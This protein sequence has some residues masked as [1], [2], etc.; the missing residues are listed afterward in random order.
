M[1]K[2]FIR[3]ISMLLALLI[4][5][6]TL[7][8]QTMA[9]AMD[10][11]PE[12]INSNFYL[13]KDYAWSLKFIANQTTTAMFNESSSDGWNHQEDFY[14]IRDG[15]VSTLNNNQ[16]DIFRITSNNQKNKF[17]Y[18]YKNVG[19][20]N[21]CTVDLKITVKDWSKL[22]KAVTVTEGNAKGRNNYPFIAFRKDK[23]DV[24]VSTV[25]KVYA[26][27]FTYQFYNHDTG[28]LLDVKG[29]TTL[30]DIDG[31]S[32]TSNYPYGEIVSFSSGLASS[33][34]TYWTEDTKLYY[35]S[36]TKS[37]YCGASGTCSDNDKSNWLEVFFDG[38]CFEFS[39]DS[40]N[41]TCKDDYVP[42]TAPAKSRTYYHFLMTSDTLAK[43][44]TPNITKEVDKAS[45]NGETDTLLYSMSFYLPAIEADSRYSS[46][47]IEDDIPEA[48]DI[49]NYNIVDDSGANRNNH[50]NFIFENSKIMVSA[51]DAASN[52]LYGTDGTT[53]QLNLECKVSNADKL[54]NYIN[55]NICTISN[56][57]SLTTE[58]GTSTSNVV[59]TDVFYTLTTNI[60]NGTISN[61]NS[62]ICPLSNETITF[63][64]DTDYYV[65]SVTVDGIEIDAAPYKNGGS[66]SFSNIKANH[67]ISVI[68]SPYEYFNINIKYLDE[69]NTPLS[70]EYNQSLRSEKS[71]NVNDIVNKDIQYYTLSSIEGVTEGTINDDVNIIVR[72]KRNKN[73]I[74]INYIEKETNSKL[75][76]SFEKTYAQGTDYNLTSEAEQQIQ[77][78]TI[79][80]IEGS[81]SGTITD[82]IVIN[83]YY[84]RNQN[85]IT[86]NYLE[87][88]TNEKL[89][90]T[91]TLTYPQGSEYDV[92]SQTN[93]N[94][95]YYTVN[96]IQGDKVNGSMDCDKVINV[97]YSR[98]QN[99]I[100]INFI[101]WITK[102]AISPFIDK[103]QEQG[104]DYN[105]IADAT[106]DIPYY[107]YYDS[108]GNLYGVLIA[109]ETINSYYIRNE[110]TITIKYVE[111]G[112]E[113]LLAD[114]V[115]Y[116]EFQGT[117]YDVTD[118]ANK[119]IACYN[120][121][122]VE[123]ASK[124]FITDDVEIIVYYTA[125]DTS[126]IV[127]YIDS[128]GKTLANSETI[129]GKV[130]DNYTT[131]KKNI[132]GYVLTETP[133]NAKGIMTEDIIVVDYIYSLKPADVIANYKTEA[134]EQLAESIQIDGKVFD[135][136]NT[137]QM[138]FYGYELIEVPEN[139]AGKMSEETIIVDY[140]YKLKD[141]SVTVNYIDTENNKLAD[142][143]VI[144]GKVFSEYETAPKNIQYYSLLV[145][146]ENSTGKMSEE[147]IV[148]NYVYSRNNNTVTINYLDKDS[149]EKLADS[150]NQVI[151]QG[152]EYDVT[153]NVQKEIEHYSL[154]S[155]IGEA[156]GF[157]TDDINIDVYYNRNVGTIV[158]NYL[159]EYENSISDSETYSG[160][161]LDEYI[162]EAKDIY[163]YELTGTPDNA[164]GTYT[165]NPITINY[166]YALKDAMVVIEHLDTD[167]N[168]LADND[169]I[170]GK[171][172][173]EYKSS[174]KL[175]EGYALKSSSDNHEG[176]MQEETIKVTYV[177]EKEQVPIIQVET[178]ENNIDKP[179][180]SPNTGAEIT[181][182]H[183][184]TAILLFFVGTIAILFKLRKKPEEV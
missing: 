74:I 106:K 52:D 129:H 150:F 85:L 66:Y 121:D 80:N 62:S 119:Q 115:T 169:T 15:E 40:Y 108:D 177:Y 4:L 167:G 102:K 137:E 36:N 91:V 142:S 156:E 7:P 124:G 69:N 9:A 97:Y 93:K 73:N 31:C 88:D 138:D 104:T 41:S 148:I 105:V 17:G 165:D 10:S 37:V 25:P 99:N 28:E 107:T 170:Y 132:Y 34:S 147:N 172:F 79:D 18:W 47:L 145:M 155:I 122:S 30:K 13:D 153:S 146:P 174:P 134:G 16:F 133:T 125:K 180:K 44:Q 70:A 173:D 38:S 57:C 26:P 12:T 35:D 20:Y 95:L 178:T 123:G 168:K 83:V 76:D 154:D 56:S 149:N 23:I 171:V 135:T 64:P 131:E 120:I 33:R 5:T 68:C 2:K 19:I 103:T 152:T 84:S 166:I 50:F 118:T 140:I 65:S 96:D 176:I 141:T 42:G 113:K 60:S 1:K 136:Y 8:I 63:T 100:I 61:G 53:Y 78:Y 77:Y 75:L 81:T 111:K 181:T 175:I 32:A 22:D 67:S 3:L 158:V 101:D 6:S 130:F 163:G 127:N 117:D 182:A 21:G 109:D 89:S 94:I 160:R 183:I 144:Y 59:N 114:T 46:L 92:H 151:S 55:N 27:Q 49:V 87:K 116:N 71:Y 126:V 72:Y 157:I 139:A 162:T 43:W 14:L 86:I 164:C 48:L 11:T 184:L 45:I 98:N 159:D 112:T 29:H 54:E 58:A 24:C 179:T 82:D 51:K 90:D 39:Y 143:N 128:N 110:N 161:V